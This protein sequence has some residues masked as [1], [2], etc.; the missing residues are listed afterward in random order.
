MGRHL[1]Q[2]RL[3]G[4]LLEGWYFVFANIVETWTRALKQ[5]YFVMAGFANA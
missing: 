5:G 3:E 2:E 4:K 1:G